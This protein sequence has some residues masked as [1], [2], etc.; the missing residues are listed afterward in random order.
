MRHIPEIVQNLEVAGARPGTVRL[1][2]TPVIVKMSRGI[3]A[4]VTSTVNEAVLNT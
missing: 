3:L 2:F 1:S 4:T